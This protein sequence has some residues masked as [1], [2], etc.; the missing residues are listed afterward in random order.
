[1]PKYSVHIKRQF[2]FN[3]LYISFLMYVSVIYFRQKHVRREIFQCN[4]S[5]DL[6]K[7]HQYYANCLSSCTSAYLVFLFIY[8]MYSIYSII[9][10]SCY[11]Q[12]FTCRRS[13]MSFSSPVLMLSLY[14]VLLDVLL[15]KSSN[16]DTVLIV[17]DLKSN[18]IECS[19]RSLFSQYLYE[20]TMLIAFVICGVILHIK[21]FILF[22]MLFE[23]YILLHFLN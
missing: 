21:I 23:F 2:Y 15:S 4:S 22:T 3:F 6:L 10:D 19:I 14:S 11:Y 8:S 17:N 7:P 16:E 9:Y 1:M 20:H 13:P 18:V 5:L 12:C